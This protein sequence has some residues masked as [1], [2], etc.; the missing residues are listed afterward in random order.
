MAFAVREVAASAD[1]GSA[2]MISDRGE[3]QDANCIY[4]K[5]RENGTY[6]PRSPFLSI[7][8]ELCSSTALYRPLVRVR[9]VCEQLQIRGNDLEAYYMH[10]NMN[11]SEI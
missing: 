9:K 5:I 8:R 7:Q 4:T 10:F 3:T 11:R 2:Y 1:I 6:E